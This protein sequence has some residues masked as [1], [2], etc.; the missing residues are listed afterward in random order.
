VHETTTLLLVTSPNIH[1]FK[2]S[3]TRYYLNF[4]AL[5][6]LVGR[7][8]GH[9]VCKK[10]EW[11]GAGVVICREQG[12]D[13]HT[14]QLRDCHSLSLASEKSGLVLPFWYRL[15]RVVP[16]KGLLNGCVLLSKLCYVLMIFSSQR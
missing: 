9:P 5:T 1:R 2:K 16:N 6:L 13:L 8:E 14:A 10:T 15:P 11:W 7:Q 12:V 4:S 3:L